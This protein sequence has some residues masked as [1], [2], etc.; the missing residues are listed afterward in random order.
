MLRVYQQHL[1]LPFQKIPNGFP[2]HTGGL[3]RYMGDSTTSQPVAQLQKFLGERSELPRLVPSARGPHHAGGHALLMYIQTTT[4][5][6]HDLHCHPPSAARRTSADYRDSS[7]CSPLLP[8]E[9]TVRCAHR[10]PGHIRT[11]AQIAP[12]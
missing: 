4:H 2:I 6:V 12:E 5:L 10:R 7:A 8:A 3:H 1:E 11:R 9:A